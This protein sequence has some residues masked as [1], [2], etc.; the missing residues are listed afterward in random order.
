MAIPVALRGDFKAS[1]LRGLAAAR[2]PRNGWRLGPH[3]RRIRGA[4]R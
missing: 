1:Q 2:K 4:A 3:D